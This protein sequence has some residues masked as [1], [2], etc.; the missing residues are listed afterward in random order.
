MKQSEKKRRQILQATET[1]FAQHGVQNT[2][3][4]LVAKEAEV[5]KRTIY[6]HFETKELLLYSVLEH[7]MLQIDQGDI[8]QFQSDKS[9]EQQLQDIAHSEVR[10]L[11]SE[12]FIRVARVAF[13]ELLQTPT[14]A[15]HFNNNK[16][17]CMRYLEQF[18][19]EAVENQVLEIEHIGFAAQQFLYQLKS[20]AFYPKL[21]GFELADA[22]S[23]EFI[24][25]QTVRLFLARYSAVKL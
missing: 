23:P 22:Q 15:S 4:D 12:P 3:M 13:I 10:L 17:G 1:L 2:S 20:F 11:T 9:I 5:S 16:I 24:V 25:E 7:M 8:Y 19:A 6:N 18:L 14:L 21:Y